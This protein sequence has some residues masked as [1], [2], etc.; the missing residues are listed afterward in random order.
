MEP[1]MEKT[2]D[3]L[4]YLMPLINSVNSECAEHMQR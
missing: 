3:L 2:R 4:Y 1:T